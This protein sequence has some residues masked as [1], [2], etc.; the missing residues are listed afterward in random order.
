MKVCNPFSRRFVTFILFILSVIVSSHELVAQTDS[1][2][3]REKVYLH[4][5]RDIYFPGDDIWFKAYLVNASDNRLTS[6]TMNLHIEMISPSSEIIASKIIR[7]EGGLGNGDFSLPYDAGSGFYR[8]RA[9]TNYKR[10]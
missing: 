5:D 9:Y 1:L 7:I 2:D 6:H 4:V 10:D 8:L 3:F